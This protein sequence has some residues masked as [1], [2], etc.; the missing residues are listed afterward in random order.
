M[1]LNQLTLYVPSGKKCELENKRNQESV[2]RLKAF[3]AI[4]F[5]ALGVPQ[6]SQEPVED[7]EAKDSNQSPAPDQPSM[8]DG[9]EQATTGTIGP[10]PAGDS[11]QSREQEYLQALD[12]LLAEE[13]WLI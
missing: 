7:V 11:F 10:K 12:Q 6:E 5:E 4:E 9:V 13:D 1:A 2:D 3:Q 8:N